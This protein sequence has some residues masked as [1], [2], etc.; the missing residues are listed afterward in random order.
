MASLYAS[1][2]EADMPQ[3]AVQAPKPDEYLESRHSSISSES[4][5]ASKTSAQN[6]EQSAILTKHPASGQA[7]CSAPRPAVTY[8]TDPL[9]REY[10]K[11]TE[12][13]DLEEMLARK[14]LRWSLAHYIKERPIREPPNP[15]DDKQRVARD[16]ETK[17]KELLEAKEQ[18]QKLNIS[19]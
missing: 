8:P 6:A 1:T 13:V 9:S 10:P 2:S 14:P 15:M 3:T 12:E 18:I 17:K 19:K 16:L 4:S 5:C 11:P 7:Y